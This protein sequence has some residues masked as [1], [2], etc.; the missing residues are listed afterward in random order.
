MYGLFRATG[1]PS[2]MTYYVHEPGAEEL[3]VYQDARPFA[4]AGSPV[5]NALLAIPVLLCLFSWLSGGVPMMTDLAFLFLLCVLSVAMTHELLYFPDRLGLGP[6]VL[7]G[8]ATVWFVHDYFSNFFGLDY[9]GF[10]ALYRPDVVAKGALFTTLFLFLAA[11]GLRIPT[12]NWLP[13]LVGKMPT[14]A[15]VNVGLFVVVVAF[16][17]GISPYFLFTDEPFYRAIMKSV[18]SMRGG[19]GTRWTVGRTGNLNYSWGGYIVHLLQIG[20]VGAMLGAFIVLMMRPGL[21]AT[22]LCFLNWML[23]AA[24][25]FGTGSRGPLLAVTL[26]VIGLVFIKYSA[27]AME[28]LQ[29]Y[30]RKAVFRTGLVL[31]VVLLAVQIQGTFRSRGLGATDLSRLSVFK[32]QGNTMFS[33]SLLVYHLFPDQLPHPRNHVV[34]QGMALFLPDTITRF[35]IGWIPRA[36]WKD[37]P[38]FINEDLLINQTMTGGTAANS[39][40]GGTIATGIVGRSYM[41]YGTMGVIQMGL[42]FGWLCACVGACLKWHLRRPFALLMTLGLA[43]WLFRSFRDLTPHDLYPLLIGGVGIY[44][45]M[46]LVPRQ[47]D[48]Q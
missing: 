28:Q 14:P 16:L 5:I 4:A 39:G 24:I 12:G 3:L 48:Y 23:W 45:L 25:A 26:P 43:T 20:E 21:I 38:G 37:K 33:E 13:R 27:A 7:Y 47:P 42:L 46:R 32:N 17:I 11:L 9:N 41:R 34:G 2:A 10:A 22:V 44:L 8:G 18:T 15:T 19:E 36:I 40:S 31:F 6:L 1:A 30:S 35:A 29:R